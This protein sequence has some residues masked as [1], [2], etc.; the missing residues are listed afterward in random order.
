MARAPAPAGGL[1]TWSEKRPGSVY[2]AYPGSDLLVEVF[3]PDSSEARRL[4]LDGD[5]GPI[6]REKASP[7]AA[8][9]LTTLFD[10]RR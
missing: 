5:V 2:V 10:Q 8:P 3:S 6:D 1:A 7:Q 9:P 4:V